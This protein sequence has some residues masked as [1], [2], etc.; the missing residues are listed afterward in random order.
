MQIIHLAVPSC[1]Y[2]PLLL[3][4]ILLTVQLCCFWCVYKRLY[5]SL[6]LL[7]GDAST[8]I[9]GLLCCGLT[10]ILLGIIFFLCFL[11]LDAAPIFWKMSFH[12][13]WCLLR[14]CLTVPAASGCPSF[15]VWFYQCHGGLGYIYSF[16][17]MHAACKHFTSLTAASKS[18]LKIFLIFL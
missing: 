6:A 16:K 7:L 5:C 14:C 3:L 1:F 15:P 11:S 9:F 18:P 13:A 2:L 8:N 12:F 17:I 4:L 10:F